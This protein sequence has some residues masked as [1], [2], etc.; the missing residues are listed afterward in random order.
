MAT[1]TLSG[2]RPID[3]GLTK[4]SQSL[5]ADA[6]GR[7]IKNKGAMFGLA[8]VIIFLLVAIF[9][10]VISPNDPLKINDGKGFLPPPWAPAWTIPNAK[11]GDPQFLLGTDNIG[12]DVFSRL[13]YGARTS[14]V[15]AI[16]PT[17]IIT[18]LGVV[19]GLLSGFI[20]GKLDDLLMRFT[21]IVFGFPDILFFVVVMFALRDTIFGEALN[22]MLLL[23]GA[24]AIVNWVGI[25]RLVRGQTL[26]LKEKEFV[27]AARSMGAK[28]AS[29]MQ[30]H[31][32][33]NILGPLIVITTFSIP[34]LIITEAILGFL[35][36]GL[37]PSTNS[38]DF[39]VT[40][41]G[42]MLLEGQ[43]AINAQPWMLLAPA[44]AV[45][46]IVMGFTFLG[47]GLRD[48]LDPR[49]RGTS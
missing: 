4:P 5:W 22:G 33:P 34:R 9:G 40:S 36:L 30:K 19:I 6:W 47:D 26:S 11:V 1:A 17:I 23:F 2:R 38:G 24:L 21:D 3:Q 27:E 45:A 35:G 46:I 37:R 49:M 41:W 32:L 42:V 13:I 31:I 15:V 44:L 14:L 20:G 48:A 16:I 12:R 10:P 18:V 39:F 8:V 43:T 29:I 28:D 7:L 25:A